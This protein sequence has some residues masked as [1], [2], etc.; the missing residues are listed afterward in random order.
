VYFNV[1]AALGYSIWAPI[2]GCAPVQSPLA[3]HEVAF[4]DDHVRVIGLPTTTLA[5]DS[6]RVIVGSGLVIVT[7]TADAEEDMYRWSPP[8]A[9]EI[10]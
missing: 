8:Y 10:E 6:F 2:T 5:A 9:A 7:V 1:P 4:V 3:A